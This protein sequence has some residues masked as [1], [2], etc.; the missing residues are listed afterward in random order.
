MAEFPETN[1]SLI[2]R[3]Q[4][5]GDGASWAEFLEIYQP[6]VF[7]MARKRGLQ[8][9]DAHDVVQQVF[10]SISRA[11]GRWE[12][13]PDKPPFRAWLTTIARN[14][15]TNSLTR[16]PRDAASGASSVIDL[17]NAHPVACLLYTSPS[18]RD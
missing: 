9:A 13:S 6:V 10:V 11:I 4:D 12:E 16:R 2:A 14:A 7:R 8:D 15:I 18:P 17:L 3:V 1:H 5:L